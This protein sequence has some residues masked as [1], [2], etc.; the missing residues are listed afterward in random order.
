MLE[1]L[2]YYGSLF[3]IMQMTEHTDFSC[4]RILSCYVEFSHKFPH[5]LLYP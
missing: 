4:V 1:K 3:Q 5:C 2:S